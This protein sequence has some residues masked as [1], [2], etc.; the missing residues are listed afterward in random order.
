MFRLKEAN[1]VMGLVESMVQ[2]GALLVEGFGMQYLYLT[3]MDNLEK[4][5]VPLGLK[6]QKSFENAKI[7]RYKVF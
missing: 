4:N 2:D 5:V 6:W 7:S 3:D 1:L